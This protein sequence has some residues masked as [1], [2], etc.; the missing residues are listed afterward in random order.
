M[1]KDTLIRTRRRE[2]GMTSVDLAQLCGVRENTIWRW[3]TGK[4]QPSRP[5]LRRLADALDVS[6][7]ELVSA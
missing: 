2:L 1:A 5:F 7:D 6:L 3:E 4:V